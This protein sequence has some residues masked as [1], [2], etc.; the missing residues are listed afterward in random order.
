LISTLAIP[1][2]EVEPF[3]DVR[4]RRALHMAVNL[5][6]V[7]KVNP[8][9]YGHG[10]ANPLVPAALTE[11]AIPINQ[12]TPEGRE[13][14]EADPAGAKRLRAQAGQSGLRF[15]VESTG[16]WGTAFSDVVQAILSEW[17]GAGIETEL[18]LKEGNAFIASSLARSFEKMIITLRG[19]HAPSLPDESLAGAAAEHRRRERSQA[20]R[21]DP[22]AAAGLRREEAARDPLRHPAP[23]RPAGLSAL[24]QPRRPGDLR[25]GALR[26]ELHAEHRQ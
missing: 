23:L 22:A 13:L 17:K 6:E 8:L 12:L 19:D 18:K 24:R 21:D 11:W 3:R 2:L 15:P 20:Q 4:V 10:A 14:C 26:A 16:T 7:I 25:L 5:N 1:K 9:G